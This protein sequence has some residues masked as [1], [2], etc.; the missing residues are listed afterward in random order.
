MVLACFRHVH[1]DGWAVLPTPQ[2]PALPLQLDPQL[3]SAAQRAVEAAGAAHRASIV[4]GDA[5]GADVS[6]AT[7]I[8][9]YLSASGNRALLQSIASTL[10]RGT[11]VVSLYFPVE[12]WD[13]SLAAHDTSCGIDIYLYEAP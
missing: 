8:A 7:V 10:R 2:R 1:P 12:G 5:A 13:G 11:R 9:L 3:A 4:C 6:D